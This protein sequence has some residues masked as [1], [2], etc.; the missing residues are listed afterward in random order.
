MTQSRD[1]TPAKLTPSPE[2]RKPVAG[3]ALPGP[4]TWVWGVYDPHP[5]SRFTFDP[6]FF[7]PRAAKA[8]LPH[9]AQVWLHRPE[10]FYGADSRFI[11][12]PRTQGQQWLHGLLL[13]ALFFPS[14]RFGRILDLPPG[15]SVGSADSFQ[16]S[17]IPW[18]SSHIQL[19]VALHRIGDTD[20]TIG[21]I[22]LRYRFP[23]DH[24]HGE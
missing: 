15:I 12:S 10:S 6:P 2:I 9:L 11:K 17:F 21:R 20:R 3:R 7:P 5:F 1:P 22:R 19:I 13:S 4:V 16:Q 24:Q 14:M 8:K 18:V 23:H